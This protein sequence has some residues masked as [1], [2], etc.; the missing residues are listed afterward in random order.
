MIHDKIYIR[1]LEIIAYHGVLKEEKELGQRFFISL[2]IETDFRE[3]GKTDD[4]TKTI[5]YAEVCDDI[6]KIFLTHKYNLIEK[7]AEEIAEFLLIKYK[8]IIE[9]KVKI[10]K[11]WAPIRKAIDHVAVEIVRKRHTAYISLGTNLGDKKENLLKALSEIDKLENTLIKKQS[12]F[13]V[14][15]PFGNVEQDDFLN[16][17]IE[18]E[19]LYT[20]RELLSVLL[21]IEKKLGRIRDIK[22]GPR[23]IDLDILIY[24]NEVINEENLIIPHPWMNERMFVLEPFAEI[25]PNVIEPVSCKRIRELKE[26]LEN[27]LK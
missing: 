4:L 8:Q 22:W 2:E 17:V 21:E 1:D 18:I 13:I 19:T 12:E 26:E 14:T 25:A 7:C 11:P 24:D 27:K 15:T 23:L 16:S 20:P 3:A 10:K 9:I 5:S 6:E